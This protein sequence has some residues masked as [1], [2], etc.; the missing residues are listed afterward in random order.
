MRELR[1]WYIFYAFII[2]HSSLFNSNNLQ[3][4][5]LRING[6]CVFQPAQFEQCMVQ[7]LQSLKEPMECKPGEINV[8]TLTQILIPSLSTADYIEIN[9]LMCLSLFVFRS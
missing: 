8:Q 2:F 1:H 3:I 7:M 6:V 9:Q 5:N 4:E